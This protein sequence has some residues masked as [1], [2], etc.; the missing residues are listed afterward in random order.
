MPP[1]LL[2]GWRAKELR[3]VTSTWS[4]RMQTACCGILGRRRKAPLMGTEPRWS[5]LGCTS[6]CG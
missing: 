5:N 4:I 1:S 2:L 3:L 6:P